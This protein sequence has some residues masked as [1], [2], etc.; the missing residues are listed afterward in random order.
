MSGK[1]FILVDLTIRDKEGR[2]HQTTV[3]EVARE[4]GIYSEGSIYLPVLVIPGETDLFPKVMEALR[5]LGE[6]ES[7]EVRLDPED[8][9]GPYDRSKVKVFSIKRLEREG[10]Q[11][12]I[13]ATI[14]LDGQRGVIKSITGGRVTVDFNHP[15]AGRELVVSGRV[16]RRI[17]DDLE[18]VRAIVADSFDVG[19][20]DIRVERVDDGVV[21]VELPSKAY[22]LRDAY[23]RKIR[24][25]SLIMRHVKSVK[26][27]RFLEEFEIPKRELEEQE[28]GEQ[29][30]EEKKEGIEAEEGGDGGEG[31]EIGSNE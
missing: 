28:K 5:E 2:V 29:S 23:S 17:E 7:F 31:G 21:V 26:K 3:E 18:K 19:L 16:V 8:A 9:Y 11:P 13:G 1:A 15:L 25:L 30:S 27:I 10:I 6:G 12:K 22:V 20:E 14:Y 4:S 24:A